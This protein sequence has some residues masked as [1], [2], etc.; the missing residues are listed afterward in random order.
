M[1]FHIGNQTCKNQN[2]FADLFAILDK[3]SGFDHFQPKINYSFPKMFQIFFNCQKLA[4][5]ICN[6]KFQSFSLLKKI[7]RATIFCKN[8][9]LISS[10]I[11]AWGKKVSMKK[12]TPDSLPSSDSLGSL[13][14]MVDI[15]ALW[16]QSFHWSLGSESYESM[17]SPQVWAWFFRSWPYPSLSAYDILSSLYYAFIFISSLL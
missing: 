4:K 17:G 10:P 2:I 7:W 3:C 6:F 15:S 1:F 5:N 12:I 8:V 9:C 11:F 13:D 16:Q 14:T